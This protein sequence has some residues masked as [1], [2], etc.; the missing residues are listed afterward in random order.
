[1][2]RRQC[3]DC[4]ETFRDSHD[5]DACLCGGELIPVTDHDHRDLFASVELTAAQHG[6][7]SMMRANRGVRAE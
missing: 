1:M 2:K 3:A 4:G 6:V 7:E 5:S